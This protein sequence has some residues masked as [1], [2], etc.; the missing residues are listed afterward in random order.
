V[1]VVLRSTYDTRRRGYKGR[2]GDILPNSKKNLIGLA[3]G[4]RGLSLAAERNWRK[5]TS[6]K[7]KPCR[8]VGGRQR[9]IRGE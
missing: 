8:I 9:G 6:E 7:E 4:L 3:Q 1:R 2:G 5:G